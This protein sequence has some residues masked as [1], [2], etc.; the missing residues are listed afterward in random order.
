M[1]DLEGTVKFSRDADV[2]IP[3]CSPLDR[4][5]GRTT[6]LCIAAHQDDIEIFAWH[7]IRQCYSSRDEW[8]TGVVVTDGAG[9]PRANQ[10]K[11]FTDQEMM[12]IRHEEQRTAASIGRY[13][14]VVQ[15][16]HPSSAVKDGDRSVEDDLAAILDRARP[17]TVYLHNPADKH[18]THVAVLLRSIAALRRMPVSLRPRLVLGCEV[19]RSLDWVNDDQKHALPLDGA[20][21]VAASIL[22]VFDSQISG[23]K[24]YDLAA[25]GRRLANAT[26]FQSHDT[27][28]HSAIT[29]A[30]NLTPLIEDDGLGIAD[31]TEAFIDGFRRDVRDRLERLGG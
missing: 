18:E 20:E 2:F 25:A 10:Y 11:D 22:G 8:F 7:G 23:G 28:D 14:A 16:L 4:A 1:H 19:W 3:D 29:F 27:D 13:S 30:L 6:H 31:F 26:F 5:L 9:S 21:N 12:A 15:L 24:R 17:H